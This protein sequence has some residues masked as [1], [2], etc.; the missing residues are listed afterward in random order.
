MIGHNAQPS[1]A[2]VENE[3]TLGNA[4]HN[5]LRIPGL[6]ATS[7][8]ILEHNGTG[9]VAATPSGGGGGVSTGK[10]IAMAMVFG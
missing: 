2:A 3:I 6:G 9:F 1:G 5:V 7:G 10:A 4:N 8:Q